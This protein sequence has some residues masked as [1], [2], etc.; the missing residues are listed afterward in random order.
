MRR[1]DGKYA[2]GSSGQVSKA[3]VAGEVPL[4]FWVSGQGLV[5]WSVVWF[6]WLINLFIHFIVFVQLLVHSFYSFMSLVSSLMWRMGGFSPKFDGLV[7]WLLGW[8]IMMFFWGGGFL[9]V[10]QQVSWYNFCQSVIAPVSRSRMIKTDLKVKFKLSAW[11]IDKT[12]LCWPA[13]SA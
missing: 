9:H 4:H 2:G 12:L 6:V 7:N 3:N 5:N 13:Q 11:I 8:L 1:R 10:L